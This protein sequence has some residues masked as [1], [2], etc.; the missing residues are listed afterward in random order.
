METYENVSILEKCSKD[1]PRTQLGKWAIGVR[2]QPADALYLNYSLVFLKCAKTIFELL[3]W[4]EPSKE[5]KTMSLIRSLIQVIQQQTNSCLIRSIQSDSQ[6]LCLT[7][8]L[9]S[10]LYLSF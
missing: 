3:F 10:S 7:F 4:T 2:A 1:T 6:D 9:L 8:I 5:I